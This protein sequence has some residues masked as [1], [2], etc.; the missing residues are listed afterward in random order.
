MFLN[1]KYKQKVQHL[2]KC[3]EIFSITGENKLNISSTGSDY[4]KVTSIK[5]GESQH[6]A[7]TSAFSALCVPWQHQ[8]NKV[9]MVTGLSHPPASLLYN[10][11]LEPAEHFWNI[12]EFHYAELI[13]SPSSHPSLLHVLCLP[14]EFISA[15]CEVGTLPCDAL[16]RLFYTFVVAFCSTRVTCLKFAFTKLVVKQIYT[17]SL[18]SST[19]NA[20]W[21]TH[22]LNSKLAVKMWLIFFAFVARCRGHKMKS[23]A[24]S[25]Y[26]CIE[27]V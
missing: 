21:E 26:W 8:W 27:V 18:L 2:I 22:S 14:S 24:A 5:W 20:D 1:C 23:R 13:S 7:Q 9:S 3:G 19:L 17:V 4:L 6:V 16:T 15:L 25:E 12:L 11:F 10:A